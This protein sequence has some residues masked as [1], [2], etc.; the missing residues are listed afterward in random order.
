MSL[1]FLTHTHTHT[2]TTRQRSKMW[3]HTLTPISLIKDHKDCPLYRLLQTCRHADKLV[4]IRPLVLKKKK[5]KS[6][7]STFL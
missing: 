3:S 7:K 5:K 4:A 1:S 6:H 2:H